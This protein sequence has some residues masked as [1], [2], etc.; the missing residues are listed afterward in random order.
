MLY[1]V[2]TYGA[3]DASVTEEL[4]N[5]SDEH[6]LRTAIAARG[7]IVLDVS[8]A[9]TPLRVARRPPRD[10]YVLFCREVR[11]LVRAGMTIVEAVDA[12]SARQK[13]DKRDNALPAALLAHLNDGL[14]LSAALERLGD[15]PVV[16]VSSIRAGERTSNLVES[17]DDFLAFHALVEQLRKKVVSAA[18]YPLIVVS[19]GAVISLF[20][21]LVV[22]PNFADMYASLRGSASGLSAT[23]I[24]VSQFVGKNRVELLTATGAM[25]SLGFWLV[26]TG[27][28][29]RLASRVAQAIPWLRARMEDFQLAMT[30]QAVALLLK[31]GYPMMDAL[32]V[33]SKSALSATI[34]SKLSKARDQIEGGSGVSQ[35]LAAQGLCDEIGRRLMAAAER[36]GNFHLAVDAVSRM[37]GERFE[38]FVERMT[39]VVEPVLLLTVAV[40]VGVIVVL[41]Y[42]PVFDLG[43]QLR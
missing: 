38:V 39:R 32:E 34:A 3:G 12:L 10:R 36:N 24:E 30:Y 26:V 23:A 11:T 14:A 6:S 2:R 16:L 4:V 8:T 9:R 37:H 33:A 28:A 22:M 40:L 21:L 1:K 31:G 17:L 13:M 41:M 7:R 19:L 35:C 20:L 43:M 25:A 42:L 29:T 5:F 18:I 15:A 27:G